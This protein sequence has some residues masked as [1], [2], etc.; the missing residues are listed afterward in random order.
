[1]ISGLIQR[2]GD[3]SHSIPGEKQFDLSGALVSKELS[4]YISFFDA[5]S[6]ALYQS[7]A[8]NSLR[9]S[10]PKILPYRLLRYSLDEY[11]Y[12]RRSKEEDSTNPK[13][14]PMARS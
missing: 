1:M 10:G 13:I 3:C 7:A 14:S 6:K 5:T 11:L 4:S 12:Q 8:L 9:G 2:S